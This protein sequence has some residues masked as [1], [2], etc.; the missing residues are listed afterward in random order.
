MKEEEELWQTVTST[1]QYS[2]LCGVPL[3]ESEFGHV[4]GIG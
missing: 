4:T 1:S 3:V 2:W